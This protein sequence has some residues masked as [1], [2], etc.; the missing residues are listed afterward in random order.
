MLIGVVLLVL[1]AVLLMMLRVPVAVSFGVAGLAMCFISGTDVEWATKSAFQLL[2]AYNFLALPLYLM[3]GSAVAESGLADRLAEFFTAL[4]GRFKGGLGAAVILT[5]AAFGAIS[6]AAM[7]ALGGLARAFLDPMERAGY[8]RWYTTALLIPACTLSQMI[9]PSAHMILYGFMAELPISMCFLAPVI[10]GLI[11]ATLLITV[12]LFMVRNVS[13]VI[14]P[15]KVDR[16]TD[17]KQMGRATGRAWLCIL[18]P[19]FILGG[20]YGGVWTP[21]EAAGGG[22][23][24]ALI[25]GFLIYRT[26]TIKKMG[27]ILFNTA[28][29]VG[30]IAMLLFFFLVISKI[31]ILAKVSDALLAG[32]LNIS[33]NKY[34]VMLMLNLL[35]IFIGMIMDDASGTLIAALILLPVARGVGWDPYHFAAIADLSMCIGLLSPPVAPVLYLGGQIAGVRLNTYIKPVMYYIIFAYIPTLIITMYVPP[36][37]TWLPYLIDKS[38]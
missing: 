38:I 27:N 8:P 2:L 26:L 30:S 19:V 31:L 15:P 14:V 17:V 22:V 7:A 29:L 24:Y 34:M 28:S 23:V 5:N 1:V 35:M 32:M 36:L 16:K 4:V 21:T 10:P 33:T 20:I 25:L 37:S 6:G 18:L 3:L 9:P 13:T 12:H 11:L